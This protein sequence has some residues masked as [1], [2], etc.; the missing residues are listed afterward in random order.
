MKN[1]LNVGAVL[2]GALFVIALPFLLI[3]WS[4]AAESLVS[5]PLPSVP[6]LG[7]C[8]SAVGASLMLVAMWQ[9]MRRGE[10]LPMNLYPPRKFVDSGLYRLVAHPIY[11]GACLSVVG[12]SLYFESAA[13]FWLITPVF[14]LSCL[15]LLLGYEVEAIEQRF[16]PRQTE[17]LL[18]LPLASSAPASLRDRINVYLLVLIPWLIVYEL[19]IFIGVP[20][21][22]IST[23]LPFEAHF[24]VLEWTELFYAFAYVFVAVFPVVARR[25]DQLR[26]FSTAVLFASAVGFFLMF[27]LPLIA[28]PKAF[29]PTGLL[30]DMLMFERAYDAPTAAFPSFHVTLAFIAAWAYALVWPRMKVVWYTL[31]CAIGLSCLTT[32]MHGL[33]DVAGGF[34]LFVAT[35]K[36]SVIWRRTLDLCQRVANSWSS[37]RIGPVRIINYAKYAGAG[38][39]LGVLLIAFVLGPDYI[40]AVLITG[41]ASILGAGIWAQVVEGASGL[42]RPFGYYGSMVAGLFCTLVYSVCTD[43]DFMVLTG[44]FVLAAPWI[45]AVGR[46][47]CFVQGCCHGKE[48]TPELG[49]RHFHPK[50]RVCTM[51]NLRGRP[52]H[53]TPLYSIIANVVTG[54]LLLR[55]Y[56]SSVD[57]ALIVGL[58]LILAG[59]SRFVEEAYRGEPQ[60]PWWGGLRLYQWAAVASVLIGI[61]VT[62]FASGTTLPPMSFSW[63]AVLIALFFGLVVFVAMGVDFPK[64]GRKLSRLGPV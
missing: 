57:A 47:R 26:S 2:Y 28:A 34:I 41:I 62:M 16:G 11:V 5:L 4:V 55:L 59:I 48:T 49:I 43:V 39:M 61:V 56:W 54:F 1:S 37:R 60:T 14:V 30:G 10:G 18:S 22:A 46:L 38:T 42:S 8:L 3:C 36:R 13:A 33:I 40:P 50:S 21:G 6:L 63:E 23:L 35:V 53:A 44:A 20:D 7:L 9:L 29:E 64:S 51:S 52:L 17:K 27:I 15:A 12:A 58:Y 32:G 24:P 45:Q 31:A 19:V 25:R